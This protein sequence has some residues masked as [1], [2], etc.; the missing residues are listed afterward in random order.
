MISGWLYHE[1]WKSGKS[2]EMGTVFFPTF[3]LFMVE[4]SGM[5]YH[6]G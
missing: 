4:G 2:E 5:G 1:G 6:E 3:M